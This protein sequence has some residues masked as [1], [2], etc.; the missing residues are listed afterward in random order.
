MRK[1]LLFLALCV[2]L[3]MAFKIDYEEAR[4]SRGALPEMPER[5]VRRDD[6]D[7]PWLIDSIRLIIQFVIIAGISPLYILSSIFFNN[8]ELYQ[9][10]LFWFAEGKLMRLSGY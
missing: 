5:T 7:F 10:H 1:A 6:S 8:Q 2:T 4:R 3:S 9:K